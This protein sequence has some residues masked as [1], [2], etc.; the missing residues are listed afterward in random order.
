MTKSALII[1]SI[2][3]AIGCNEQIATTS[4]VKIYS[5]VF[6]GD[7]IPKIVPYELIVNENDS[8][9]KFEYSNLTNPRKSILLTY[10][11][12]N[13]TLKF[14]MYEYHIDTMIEHSLKSL[15]NP[16]F[17]VFDL[18]DASVADATGPI[19]LDLDYGLLLIKNSFGTDFVF[20]ADSTSTEQANKIKDLNK[21]K[22]VA[23]KK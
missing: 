10:I 22:P 23:N 17:R 4:N 12:E 20:L 1:L 6:W 13:Q 15:D 21:I 9:K 8:L 18:R 5:Y 3:L 11:K 2:L 14:G 7:T 16:K 19:V